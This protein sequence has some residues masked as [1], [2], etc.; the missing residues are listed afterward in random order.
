M[1]SAEAGR[2]S[3]CGMRPGTL[4]ML[5]FVAFALAITE[6]VFVHL[7]VFVL[8]PLLLMAYALKPDLERAVV[9]M[10]ER[11]SPHES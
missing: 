5:T 7:G 10:R 2:S 9:R 11:R 3:E 6:T 1:G 8:A 4:L